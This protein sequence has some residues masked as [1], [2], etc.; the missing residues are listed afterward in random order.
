VRSL[1]TF[2][3]CAGKAAQCGSKLIVIHR[4]NGESM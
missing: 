2:R 4:E 3:A 1:A